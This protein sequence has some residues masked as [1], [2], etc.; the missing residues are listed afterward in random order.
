MIHIIQ[1]VRHNKDLK[2]NL[3]P[4]GQLDD[5]GSKTH[6]KNGITNIIKGHINGDEGKESLCKLVY[7]NERNPK[8]NKYINNNN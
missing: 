5:L 7:T 8:E 1:E 6:V 4:I 2:K 3:F